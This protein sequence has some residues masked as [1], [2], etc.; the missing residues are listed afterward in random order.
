MSVLILQG[1]QAGNAPQPPALRWG[2]HDLHTVR[3]SDIDALVSGLRAVRE[4]DVALV[5]LEGGDLHRSEC[6]PAWPAL[7]E[8]IDRLPVPYIELEDE[9][10]DELAPWLQPRHMPL[11]TLITPHDRARGYALSQAIALRRLAADGPH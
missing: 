9:A 7:R 2:N 10:A 3:C 11:A 6:R 5:V 8:A 1:P 4:G